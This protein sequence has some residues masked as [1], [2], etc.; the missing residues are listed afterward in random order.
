MSESKP[1]NPGISV[2]IHYD[3]TNGNDLSQED[4]LSLAYASLYL[5]AKRAPNCS[6]I[7]ESSRTELVVTDECAEREMGGEVG[8]A[9]EGRI[10]KGNQVTRIKYIMI[11]QR[12]IELSAQDLLM[13]ML[14]HCC[15][16]ANSKN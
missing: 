14:E 16:L 3:E 8:P 15:T 4:L 11:Y 5:K 13:D 12:E 7:F 9:F 6:F 1:L 2:C 10:V